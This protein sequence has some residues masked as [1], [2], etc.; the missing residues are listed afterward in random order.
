MAKRI[1][2]RATRK[3][4]RA[5]EEHLNRALE[6]VD[7]EVAELL[8]EARKRRKASA[9]FPNVRGKPGDSSSVD[10]VVYGRDRP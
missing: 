5:E 4:T 1:A 8:P 9:L 10:Q 7:A 6:T 3:L 2:K